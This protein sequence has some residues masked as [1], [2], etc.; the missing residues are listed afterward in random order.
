MLRFRLFAA[1]YEGKLILNEGKERMMFICTLFDHIMCEVVGILQISTQFCK[2]LNPTLMHYIC[3]QFAK[4]RNLQDCFRIMG[5]IL[6]ILEENF[7]PDH[8]I[9]WV[10]SSF[11]VLL[12][13]FSYY[14]ARAYLPLFT[15][16][17]TTI[18]FQ[19]P[20]PDLIPPVLTPAL[21]DANDV[22]LCIC[23]WALKMLFITYNDF[24]LRCRESCLVAG[25][26][27]V[28]PQKRKEV[29][30]WV[31]LES[32]KA[33]EFWAL[34]LQNLGFR[35]LPD[36][37]IQNCRLFLSENPIVLLEFVYC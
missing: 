20:D 35:S 1:S 24:F 10:L 17:Y 31:W 37:Q 4:D 11:F 9:C 7:L 8:L 19:K 34:D 3:W 6:Q 30:I 18:I 22:S 5:Q 13:C 36:Q 14:I 29:S 16:L 32:T 33:K 26:E 15:G 12:I 27:T 21:P 2:V 25:E 28:H 23:F